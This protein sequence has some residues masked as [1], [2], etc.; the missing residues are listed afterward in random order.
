MKN[1]WTKFNPRDP[2]THPKENSRVEMKHADGSQSSGGFLQG[3][4]LQGGVISASGVGLTMRWR[5]VQ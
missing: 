3:H 1:E 5:Y 2:N 4:F